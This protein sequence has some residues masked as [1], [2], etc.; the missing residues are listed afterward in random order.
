MIEI[1]MNPTHTK[2]HDMLVTRMQECIKGYFPLVEHNGGLCSWLACSLIKLEVS[3]LITTLEHNFCQE[4]SL[5]GQNVHASHS[6]SSIYIH[7]GAS[8]LVVALFTL[9]RPLPLEPQHL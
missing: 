7:A 6:L 3:G 5:T 4:D 8:A 9:S 1:P 2:K